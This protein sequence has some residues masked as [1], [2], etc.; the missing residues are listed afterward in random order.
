VRGFWIASLQ[1]RRHHAADGWRPLIREDKQWYL[2]SEP[3][4]CPRHITRVTIDRAEAPGYYDAI[5]VVTPEGRRI[6]AEGARVAG[7]YFA[8]EVFGSV[9]SIPRVVGQIDSDTARITFTEDQLPLWQ[10]V[11]KSVERR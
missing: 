10:R 8:I 5:I 1:A 9:H 6:V 3:F 4:L 7:E 2:D 11:A